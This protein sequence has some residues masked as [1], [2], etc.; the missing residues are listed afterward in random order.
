MINEEFKMKK[1]Q[2]NLF[3]EV[4]K[5]V[6]FSCYEKPLKSIC[7]MQSGY[8]DLLKIVTLENMDFIEALYLGVL[9]RTVDET[10][11]NKFLQ[12]NLSSNLFQKLV[13]QSVLNSGEYRTRNIKIINNFIV[14]EHIDRISNE[15]KNIKH[16]LRNKL[17]KYSKSLQPYLNNKFGQTLKDFFKSLLE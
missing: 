5:K 16:K 2:E 10:T 12:K 9:N 17:K 6:D 14:E 11:K 1:I 13:L 3:L 7:G 8:F 4:N 15:N